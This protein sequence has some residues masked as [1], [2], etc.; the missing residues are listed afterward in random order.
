MISPILDK[1]KKFAMER[2]GTQVRKFEKTPYIYHPISV[3][4]RLMEFTNDEEMI[5]AAYL[6]DVLE[7]TDTSYHEIKEYFNQNIANLVRELTN[8]K[9]DAQI[10]G[11]HVYIT[12]KINSMTERAR[13]I[14]FI[15]RED[16]VKE[17]GNTP[18]EF[19]KRYANETAY[20][21]NHLEFHPFKNEAEVIESIWQKIAP[22]INET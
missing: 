8:D 13:L 10:I 5:A 7:D 16:N 14:K 11:K 20:I 6:H 18:K 21:L 19:Q 9:Q 3:A 4:T 12:K 1:A 15:D 2:H 17:I 22:F